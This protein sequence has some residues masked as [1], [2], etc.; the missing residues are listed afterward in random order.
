MII[1]GY[2]YRAYLFLRQGKL[3]SKVR[4]ASLRAF[5]AKVHS[6]AFISYGSR[7]FGPKGIEIGAHSF[8]GPHVNIVA[9][10]TTVKIGDNVLIAA[11][12]KIIGRNH[13]YESKDKTIKEQGY[14]QAPIVIENNVWIGYH[15]VILSGVTIGEGAIIAAGSVVTKDV[16]A[17]K[18][19]GGIP[20]RTLKER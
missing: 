2:L 16:G 6:T 20:A 4:A 13:N 8:I 18:I 19:V 15:V 17:N 7:F 14:V 3:A 9:N 10:D 5:K 12:T 11:G 1:L